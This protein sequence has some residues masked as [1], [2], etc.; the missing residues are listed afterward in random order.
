MIA[1][2][3]RSMKLR[4]LVL[5]IVLLSSIGYIMVLQLGEQQSQ[6][7]SIQRRAI[8][9]SHASQHPSMTATSGS[10]AIA[11][12]ALAN[13]ITAASSEQ[14]ETLQCVT[15]SGPCFFMNHPNGSTAPTRP[16]AAAK[17][18]NAT[19]EQPKLRPTSQPLR[20]FSLH[21][22]TLLSGTRFHTAQRTNIEWLRTLDPDRLLYYFRNLSRLA[23]PTGLRP[24]GGWDGAGTGLR[25]HIVGHY[26][27]AASMA[28]AT[29]GDA[30]LRRNL[31][32][33]TAGLEQCQNALGE[34]GYLSG[35]PQSEFA[36]MEDVPARPYAWV[37]YYVMHKLLAG[38]VDYHRLWGSQR[39][40]GVAIRLAEHLHARVARVL[41]RGM[42]AWH[43]F[44]NQEVG[45]MSEVL[46]DLSLATGESRWL[47]LAAMFERPCFLRP[48]ILAYQQR[49]RQRAHENRTADADGV[50]AQDAHLA[51]MAI[52]RMHTCRS[53]WGRWHAMKRPATAHYVAR[54]KLSGRS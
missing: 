16:V 14:E 3:L 25:G 42:G 32:R 47:Q 24:H 38:L 31:E 54:R 23:S 15:Y 40:L 20:P 44:I 9:Q 52:E 8:H 39:A 33:I 36:Q 17:R 7:A 37:P 11:L 51:A 19:D 43:T 12:N 27:S 45:G 48:L 28:A 13:P 46:T 34:Q 10:V 29:T 1:R 35:F 2:R 22:V 49:Q 18:P 4:R 53:Y 6:Q 41:T 5:P 50:R 26:L 30:L 21:N